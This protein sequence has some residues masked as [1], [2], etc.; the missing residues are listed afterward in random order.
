MPFLSGLGQAKIGR[1]FF[2]SATIPGAPTFQVNPS[3]SGNNGFVPVNF[4][5]PAFNGGLPVTGYKYS[6]S[7][8]SDNITYSSYGAYQNSSWSSGTS[9]NITGLTNG[10]FYKIKIKAVNALGDG[11]ESSEIGPFKPYTIPG[12]PQST[13]L[14]ISGVG[15]MSVSYTAPLSNGRRFSFW[16]PILNQWWI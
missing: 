15:A 16:L 6:L 1:G 14:S 4:V 7:T 9:F 10:T 11:L 12:A 3:E 5:A 2:A 13:A 8:S